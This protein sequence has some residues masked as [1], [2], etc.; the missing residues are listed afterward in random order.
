MCTRTQQKGAMPPQETDPDLPQSVHKYLAE[1][2]VSG[3]LLQGQTSE[4][5]SVCMGP[6]E[7]GCHYLHYLHHSLASGQI[8]GREHSTTLPQKSGLKLY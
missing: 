1:V 8:T 4:G 5:S 7:G 3:G 2:W 6:F